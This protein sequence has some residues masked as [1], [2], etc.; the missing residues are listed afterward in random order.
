MRINT[1]D[2]QVE[3]IEM[4]LDSDYS[5]YTNWYRLLYFLQVPQT[6][7]QL[8]INKAVETCSILILYTFAIQNL[9]QPQMTNSPELYIWLLSLQIQPNSVS[10]EKILLLWELYISQTYRSITNNPNILNNLL[11]QI[12]NKIKFLLK[13]SEDRSSGGLWGMLGFGSSS[14][15]SVRFRL[16][17]RILAIFILTQMR[18]SKDDRFIGFRLP[19]EPFNLSLQ[20][21]KELNHLNSLMKVPEYQSFSLLIQNV[22]TLLKDPSRTMGNIHELTLLLVS[23]P[24]I[25][26][27]SKKFFH[28]P[29]TL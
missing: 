24:V 10:E 23:S 15:Y 16:L 17:S 3:L 9:Q 28:V 12:D 6:G 13:Y 2:K 29:W 5:V 4:C 14:S 8:F 19:N 27:P 26:A 7:Q 18:F 22:I 1:V 21:A 25:N 20:A 11:P